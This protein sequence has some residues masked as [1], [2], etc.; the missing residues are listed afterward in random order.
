MPDNPFTGRTVGKPRANPFHAARSTAPN[1][2][3]QNALE[4][5][6]GRSASMYRPDGSM[7]GPGFLGPIKNAIGQSREEYSI[8]VNI[9]GKEMEIPTFVPTLTAQELDY[10]TNMQEGMPIPKS[11]QEKAVGHAL[12]RM[13]QGQS[14]FHANGPSHARR[15]P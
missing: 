13:R 11:I 15:P 5:T 9:D 14:P 4:G 7:K 10:L 12:D 3:G 1:A 2:F 6:L 8:G